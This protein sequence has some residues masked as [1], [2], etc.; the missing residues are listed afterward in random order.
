MIARH[1]PDAVL[2]RVFG[3]KDSLDAV[4]LCAAFVGGALIA[5]HADARVV[6]A[7]GR[8]G[9]AGRGA[10]QHRAAAA[11]RRRQ[12][13]AHPLPSAWPRA[14]RSGSAASAPRRSRSARPAAEPAQR[15]SER[16]SSTNSRTPQPEPPLAAYGL[17]RAPRRPGDVQVRPRHVAGEAL[18][19]LRRDARARLARLVDV[20]EV[21]RVAVERLGVVGVQRQAPD[22]LAGRRRRGA[23]LRGPVVVGGE[24]AGVGVAQRDDDRAGQRGDVDE[25]LGALV[26]RVRQAVGQHEAALGVGVDDLD[27]RA[28]GGA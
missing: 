21:G 3:L 19:E 25:P 5:S 28:V 12:R 27:R 23:D 18:Q 14:A 8:R 22:G 4:A 26:D 6:F 1:A 2:G 9:G 17:P 24:Q 10:R 15:A 11:R 13:A 16:A 20:H 7:V